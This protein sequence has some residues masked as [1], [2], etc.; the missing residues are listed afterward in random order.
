M[1]GEQQRRLS[2]EQFALQPIDNKLAVGSRLSFRLK[3]NSTEPI[4][5]VP[6]SISPVG[7]AMFTHRTSSSEPIISVDSEEEFEDE[8]DLK[9]L[10]TEYVNGVIRDPED[11]NHFGNPIETHGLVNARSRV[12][13]CSMEDLLETVKSVHWSA[14]G[15]EKVMLTAV[16]IRAEIEKKIFEFRTNDNYYRLAFGCAVMI[17]SVP[18][19]FRSWMFGRPLYCEIMRF[20]TF[21]EFPPPCLELEIKLDLWTAFKLFFVKVYGTS[22]WGVLGVFTSALSTFALVLVVLDL[23]SGAVDTFKRR[24]LYAKYFSKL[25]SSRRA[26]KADLPHF[27][28]YK[29]DHIK[30]WLSL[31]SRRLDL[32]RHS[33]GPYKS[34]DT[35]AHF[36][37]MVAIFLVGTCAVRAMQ[38]FSGKGDI[39]KASDTRSPWSLADWFLIMWAVILAA[40]VQRIML[41]ASKT[42][43]RFQNTSVLL[44]EEL[45]IHMRLLRAK[46]EKKDE[47]AACNSMLKVAGSLIKELEGAKSKKGQNGAFVLDPWLYSLVRVILLSAL[48]ALSSDLF[49]FRVRLWKI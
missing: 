42:H 40:Y 38:F 20:A 12:F 36:L 30:V 14:H 24:F 17:A 41:L 3:R 45:N 35:V 31:R 44:T 29:V 5:P 7:G 23:I 16:D 47:L 27:R 37:F 33:I 34:S 13:S 9:N 1:S 26:R 46:P 22:V 8:D 32:D 49:G 48:G 21:L 2:G 19:I 18:T 6:A 15:P 25:T 28:L 4:T 39:E 10:S 11:S 43:E